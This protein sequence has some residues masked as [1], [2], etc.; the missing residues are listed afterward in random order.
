M[1]D[2]DAILNE[3]VASGDAPF[4]VAMTGNADGVTWS[5]HAGDRVPGTPASED[6]VFRI[7]SMTKAIGSLAAMILIDRGKLGIETPVADVIP[8]FADIRV[9]E[10][11]DD[12]G[13]P[14]TREPRT[15]ATIR[16]LATHTTGFVYEIWNEDMPRYMEATE[17]PSILTG[18]KAALMGPL[19]FDPGTRWD[20]GQ[21]IDWLG[22]AVEAVDGR[23]IDQFCKEEIFD[24]L[25]MPDTRFE[26]EGTMAD[27]L[28]DV[29][30]RGE[31]GAF[32]DMDLAPPPDPEFYGMGHA[33]YST[34]PDYMRFLRMLLNRGSLD[35]AT[36]L[37]PDG[38]DT[39][40]ENHIGDLRLGLMKTVAPPMSAD[41]DM[42]P[43]HEKTHSFGFMR[44]EVD[45]PGMR[46]AGAQ[47][48]AGVL[49]SHYWF[50]PA[51]DVAGLI[52]TQLLPFVDER[53]MG[54]YERFE[55]GVYE[56]L[57]A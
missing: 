18:L 49:N 40:L 16:H 23:R 5:G 4:L 24:P 7:F 26:L 13:K 41:V 43:G 46:S 52:M 10:G 19:M 3:A 39:L 2:L 30:A 38:V 35:G 33:L 20:Y 55:K 8:A 42:F 48:W 34:A 53:F 9:L 14:I 37:S 25:G 11:H 47:A 28:A 29:A 50:D 31:D 54:V 21:G 57:D 56:N 45:V 27:R 6:T 36:V 12:E 1:A 51:R 32:V 44:M 17:H 15:T 22:Q